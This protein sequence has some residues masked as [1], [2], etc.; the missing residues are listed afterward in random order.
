VQHTRG[1]GNRSNA[2]FIV[3]YGTQHTE[4]LDYSRQVLQNLIVGSGE[5]IRL[6]GI[7]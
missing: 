3:R 7:K 5:A 6:L 1:S 2:V 4:L